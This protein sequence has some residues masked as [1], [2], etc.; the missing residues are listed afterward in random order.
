ME[1]GEKRSKIIPANAYTELQ[2]GE[3]YKPVVPAD[4]PV[5]EITPRSV[6]MGVAGAVLFTF[7]A[8]YIGLKTGNVIETAI[9]IAILAIFFGR[10]LAPRNTLL[11][12]VIVQSIGAASGVVP[13]SNSNLTF[14][15]Y[16]SPVQSGVSW[17]LSSSFRFA[18]ISF[19]KNTANSPSRRP[20]RRPRFWPRARRRPAPERARCC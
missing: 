10:L 1:V 18:A 5:A 7:A 13:K 16:S 19:V 11:Q 12:N 6:L 14:S 9:P 20:R 17:A 4:K 15:R 8:S 2:P 3:E